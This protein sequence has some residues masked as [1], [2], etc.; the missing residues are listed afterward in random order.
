MHVI[1]LCPTYGRPSLVANSLALFLG[2]RLRDGD[3]AHLL[4]L[5]D[6]GQ[7]RTQR[8]GL[9]R[10]TWQVECRREWI[11]LTRKYAPMLE[12]SGDWRQ[13]TSDVAHVVWDDDDVYLPWH[14]AA[15]AAALES[16]PW[17]HPSRAWSTYGIDPTVEPPAER[18]LS[19]RHYHGA[20]AVRGDLMAELG[21]W[22][23]T[24][25]SDY[26][27]QM[28]ACCR[29]VAGP[30]GDPCQ[31]GPP[32]YVYRWQDTGRDH[33]SGRSQAGRYQPPRIQEPGVVDTLAPR[34]DRSTVALLAR[35]DST[36]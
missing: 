23:K 28:L 11:P 15:H 7:I 5:D 8:G 17:S 22:P 14:L 16:R 21:G 3:S 20:L 27:K 18:Q 10:L 9:D 24:D 1:C 13:A 30:P 35:L 6:A 33:C 19:G 2:Q 29:D 34:Y 12:L 25:R 36:R 26:D 32:S 4:I 31:F